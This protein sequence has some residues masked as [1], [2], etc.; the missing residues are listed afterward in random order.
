MSERGDKVMAFLEGLIFPHRKIIL[1]LFMVATV[2]MVWSA[3][4]L[5]VDA[6]FTKLLPLKHRYMETFVKHRAEFGG[7]NRVLIALMVEEGDI[8][9]P[10][11][12]QTLE[13]ATNEVFFHSR[14][15]PAWGALPVHTERP[16]RGDHRRGFCRRQRYP[17]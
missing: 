11:F 5:R 2:F 4:Q 13:D 6:G 17:E 7:A 16:I 3:A 10:E 14:R 8:F 15:Q 12:F 9:T 1:L